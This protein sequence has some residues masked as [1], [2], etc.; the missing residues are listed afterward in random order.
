MMA[1]LII[2][3]DLQ[4]VAGYVSFKIPYFSFDKNSIESCNKTNCRIG[5]GF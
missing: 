1:F 3:L 4:T 2:Q 5:C